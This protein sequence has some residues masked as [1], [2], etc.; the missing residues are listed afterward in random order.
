MPAPAEARDCRFGEFYLS[1]P[2]DWPVGPGVTDERHVWPMRELS[3]LALL[4]HVSES[5]IWWGHTVGNA[6]P[7]K[8]ITPSASFTA[9]ILGWHMSLGHQGCTIR[10]G[11]HRIQIMVALPIYPAELELVR[12]HGSDA[13]FRRLSAAG[14]TD[15]VDVGRR[16]TAT[17]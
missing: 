16:D 2:E 11:H 13:L 9:W 7:H 4:P 15:V 12:R 1:L 17:G 14:V 8:R 5:W 3:D 6:D 10:H